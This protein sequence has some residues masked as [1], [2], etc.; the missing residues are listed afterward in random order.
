MCFLYFSIFFIVSQNGLG[1]KDLTAHPVPPPALGWLP[2]T[3]SGCPGPIQ[4]GPEHLQ[5][6]GI[7][8]PLGSLCQCLTTL[9]VK[10][11]LLTSNLNLPLF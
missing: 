10:N 11:F 6:W 4:P 1:W 3:T 7:H 2:P 9:I 5:G 8:G